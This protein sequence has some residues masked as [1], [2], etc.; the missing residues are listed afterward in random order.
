LVSRHKSQ[1]PFLYPSGLLTLPGVIPPTLVPE[2]AEVPQSQLWSLGRF[3]ITSFH[4]TPVLRYIPTIG[5][6]AGTPVHIPATVPS[7]N[8]IPAG[9]EGISD[10][11]QISGSYS[12]IRTRL[13]REAKS[14][15]SHRNLQMACHHER[16]HDVTVHSAFTAGHH[17]LVARLQKPPPHSVPTRGDLPR[18]RSG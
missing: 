12:D 15:S 9:P 5:L 4:Y 14:D 16:S 11:T 18:K 3:N 13:P 10:G 1:P 6:Y 7:P 2:A 8:V 17:D